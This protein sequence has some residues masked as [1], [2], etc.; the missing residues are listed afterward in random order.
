MID[1]T[2]ALVRIHH[3]EAL[4]RAERARMVKAARRRR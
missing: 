4:A 2:H 3:A 1:L